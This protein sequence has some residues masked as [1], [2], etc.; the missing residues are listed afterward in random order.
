MKEELI[1]TRSYNVYCDVHFEEEGTILCTKHNTIVC[2]KCA[3]TL[4]FDHKDSFKNIGK[5]LILDYCEKSV[6]L[7]LSARIKL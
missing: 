2:L 5:D 7:L 4:H 1:K 3:F 6:S